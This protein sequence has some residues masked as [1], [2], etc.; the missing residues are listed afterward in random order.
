ML[1]SQ[2]IG[3]N[4]LKEKLI[5]SVKSGRIPHAQLFFGVDGVGS[6]ALAIAYAQY[7]VCDNR[8]E[9]DSCGQC[10]NCLKIS[11][12]SHPDLH[13]SFPVNTAGKIS[14]D[15][16]SDNF[17]KEWREF[18]ISNPYFSANQWYE[19]IGIEKKQGLINKKESEEILRKLR[20]KAFESEYKFMIIWLPEK[21]NV[22]SA[23]VLLKLIEEPP[24]NTI[25]ILVSAQ[26]EQLLRTITSRTQPVKL[27][28]I[29]DVSLS[30]AIE[31]GYDFSKE[32]LSNIVRLSGGSYTK[33]LEIILSSEE[34]QFNLDSFIKI[35]RLC[36]SR[37]FLEVNSWVDEMSITGREKLKSFFSYTLKMIR[38]NFILNMNN[39]ALNYLTKAE[40]DFSKK[41]HPYINGNNVI[42]L[43]DEISKASFDIERNGYAKIILFDL[44]LRLMKLI[45]GKN[46]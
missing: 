27:A 40:E 12:L 1:F 38:E 19:C 9:T 28:R 16:V 2:V 33:T 13:F 44:T 21:M 18:V 30:K 8:T 42:K 23:N 6:L 36:Y 35:M 4:E 17:I 3:Q 14:K 32:K 5:F 22:S 15:P 34:N 26:P 46:R 39:S 29:D 11:K 7:I 20:F 31:E 43:Y 41:F 25:F 24:E 10:A 37:S 45:P